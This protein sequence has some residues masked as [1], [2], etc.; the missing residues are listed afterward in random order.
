MPSRQRGA[1]GRYVTFDAFDLCARQGACEGTVEVATLRRLADRLS[2]HGP[3]KGGGSVAWCISGGSVATGRMALKVEIDGSVSLECQRCLEPFMWPVAQQTLLLL[4]RDERELAQLDEGYE[5]EVVLAAGPL[6]PL[7]LVEDELLLTLPFAPR[8][9][10]PE[11]G[12]LGAEASTPPVKAS[13]FSAL[14][15]RRDEAKGGK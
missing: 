8:C 4:A 10:R 15:G 1:P 5:Y 6:D 2:V 7:D 11:C 14:A 13:A 9:T 12:G 3:G